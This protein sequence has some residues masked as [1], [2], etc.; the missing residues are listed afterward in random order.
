[1]FK[2]PVRGQDV[3]SSVKTDCPV[4]SKTVCPVIS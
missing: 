1:M 2:A 3:Q 4:I